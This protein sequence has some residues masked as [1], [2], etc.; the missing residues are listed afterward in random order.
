MCLSHWCRCECRVLSWHE[1]KQVLVGGAHK[2][3][4]VN[5]DHFLVFLFMGLLF[6]HAMHSKDG[7]ASRLLR[8]RAG[9][10]TG[11]DLL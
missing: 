8:Q 1:A 9:V 10:V 5:F 6:F 3:C 7:A 2:F 4:D 11:V